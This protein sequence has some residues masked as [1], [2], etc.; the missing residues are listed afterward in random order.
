MVVIS[1]SLNSIA[2]KEAERT[3]PRRRTGKTQENFISLFLRPPR[4]DRSSKNVE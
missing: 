4:R 2:A 3:S 1:A